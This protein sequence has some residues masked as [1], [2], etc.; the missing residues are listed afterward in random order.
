MAA[1]IAP[2]KTYSCRLFFGDTYIEVVS[3]VTDKSLRL[4]YGPGNWGYLPGAVRQFLADLIAVPGSADD[5]S[6]VSLS[7][8]VMARYKEIC[9][10]FGGKSAEAKAT[11]QVASLPPVVAPVAPAIV[12]ASTPVAPAPVVKP[13]AS[14]K[15]VDQTASARTA[16]AI[17]IHQRSQGV[18]AD[19]AERKIT[20]LQDVIRRA[21]K[22]YYQVEYDIQD[23]IKDIAP[24]PSGRTWVTDQDTGEEWIFPGM[25]RFGFRMSLS[26]WTL[27]EEMLNNPTV[28]R[29]LDHY[30]RCGMRKLRIIPWHPEAGAQIRKIAEEELMEEVRR[31][32]TALIQGID[33]ADIALRNAQEELERRAEEGQEVTEKD[34]ARVQS[35]RD[36]AIRGRLKEAIYDLESAIKSAELFDETENVRDLLNGLRAAIRSR[37]SSFNAEMEARGGRLATLPE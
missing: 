1:T 32:H 15:P 14:V 3:Q 10:R 23:T 6:E 18:G 16:L 27:S 7:H 12:K 31:Q 34:R 28:Q 2:T 22:Q 19:E 21:D 24:N 30:R 20:R 17:D 8:V 36:S 13:V 4:P 35:K 25:W 37:A 29:L 26:C 5:E 33:N 9:D 11:A